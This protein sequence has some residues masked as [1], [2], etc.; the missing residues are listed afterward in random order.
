MK[1]A[2]LAL[3]FWLS[4][5][6]AFASQPCCS[7]MPSP[8]AAC[9]GC[10]DQKESDSSPQPDCC[11]SFEAPK[12]IDITVPR[13]AALQ[14][15]VATELLSEAGIPAFCS[16]ESADLIAAEAASRAEGPPLYLRYLVLLI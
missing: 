13:T 9:G 1:H 2:V 14:T 5:A 3:G 8:K 7:G 10:C 6:P 11:S 4:S 16:F 15:F 12:D